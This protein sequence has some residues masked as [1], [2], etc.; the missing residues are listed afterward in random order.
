MSQIVSY[1]NEDIQKML[2]HHSK[3]LV[4]MLVPAVNSDSQSANSVVYWTSV[5][6]AEG[7][8]IKFEIEFNGKFFFL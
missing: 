1:V 4:N 3:E 2:H 5:G 6:D 8:S 7:I